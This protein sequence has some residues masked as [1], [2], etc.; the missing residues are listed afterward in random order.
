MTLNELNGNISLKFPQGPKETNDAYAFFLSECLSPFQGR[1]ELSHEWGQIRL[2]D[3]QK[4]R[5]N[6]AFF[7]NIASGTQPRSKHFEYYKCSCGAKMS[8]NSDHGCVNCHRATGTTLIVSN[9]PESVTPAQSGCFDCSIYGTAQTVFGPTCNDFGTPAFD[10][11]KDRGRC[12]CVHCC[13]YEYFSKY[14][15]VRLRESLQ[16][17]IKALP[18]PL[19]ESGKAFQGGRATVSDV[20]KLLHWKENQKNNEWGIIE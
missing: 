1:S 20:N 19:S 6:Y 11:C 15:P 16:E 4:N 10:N 2:Y 5:P 14:H 12:K 17:M 18:E 8:A 13:R 3:G 9:K 7:H